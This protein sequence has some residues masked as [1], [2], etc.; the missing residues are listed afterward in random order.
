MYKSV[1]YNA[2]TAGRKRVIYLFFVYI[3][4]N[5]ESSNIKLRIEVSPARIQNIISGAGGVD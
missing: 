4:F 3:I 2:V 5:E 1:F